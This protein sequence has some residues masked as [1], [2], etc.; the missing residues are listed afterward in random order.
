MAIQSFT[1]LVGLLV[2]WGIVS[3]GE[4]K[5]GIAGPH[6]GANAAF[7]EQLW[8]GAEAAAAEINAAG[9]INGDKIVLVKADDAC[10][11]KQAVTVANKLVHD[12]K[13]AAVVG[14]FC[15]SSTMPASE[16]YDEA[17]ILNI[18]PAST[19]PQVTE[20][21]LVTTIRTCGRDDQQGNVAADFIVKTLKAK[22]VVILHDK[23][24]YGLGLANAMKARLN[25]LSVKESLFEGLT[26]GEKDFNALVTKIKGA[27]ADV[28]YFGGLHSEA[29]PLLRQMRDQ[30]VKASFISGD[31]IVSQDFANAAGGATYV[32]GVYMTFGADARELPSGKMVVE[33]LRKKGFEPEGYTLYSYATLESIR[34]AM[35]ATKSK[36]GKKLATWL[37]SNTVQTVM[38][39]KSWDTKG[40]LKV[41]DY[42]IYKW[43]AKGK[44]AMLK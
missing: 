30:G 2:S 28:V 38:G 29:G 7:G 14:H 6:S 5:I 40:D 26:R 44:Y 10:E 18:T 20:R 36:D 19:N 9:G 23:D 43:D 21:K 41:S 39:P 35:V 12:D 13:V 42:V 3:A 11:P 8:R 31:G 27:S 37:K 15:S 22:K 32:N 24:T 4:I 16:V 1:V 34:D 17:N 33:K 25:Q